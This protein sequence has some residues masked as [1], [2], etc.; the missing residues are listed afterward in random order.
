[1]FFYPHFYK[2][3]SGIGKD[4]YPLV[5]FDKALLN[6]EIGDYNLIKVSS[7]LPSGCEVSKAL[8][9]KKG[10]PVLCAY[11]TV[12]SNESGCQLATAIAVG[13]PKDESLT[14]VIMEYCGT[15]INAIEA[16]NHACEMVKNAMA[17]RNAELKEIQ[18]SSIDGIVKKDTLC[19]V[20][21]LV[22]W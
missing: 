15:G 22:M 18:F 8:T 19:L 21:A 20:S 7:I 11:A 4:V 6:A 17:I 9:I 12:S 10:A 1:M 3:S 2:L 5:A 16:R 13:I 14:G